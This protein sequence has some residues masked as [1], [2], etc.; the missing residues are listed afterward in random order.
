MVI[1]WLYGIEKIKTNKIWQV[2]SNYSSFICLDH[3]ELSEIRQFIRFGA[4][5]F[6]SYVD[7][8][9]LILTKLQNWVRNKEFIFTP[10]ISE[11]IMLELY[12]K[13]I[14][15]RSSPKLTEK[16]LRIVAML[17]DGMSYNQILLNVGMNLNTVRYHVKQVLTKLGI[18][19]ATQ[20][21]SVS[22]LFENRQ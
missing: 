16:Q 9:S 10:R 2:A 21:N 5:G 3:T 7:P 11:K 8:L 1:Y 6:F 14:E 18:N 15:L 4:D 13:S 20:L 22:Y 17:L 12:V 19:K